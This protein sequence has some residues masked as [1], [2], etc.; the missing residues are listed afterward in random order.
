MQMTKH[1]VQIQQRK[2]EST[3]YSLEQAARGIG[4][5]QNACK[6]DYMYF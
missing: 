5:Y 1:F 2:A 4:F 3:L 6:R